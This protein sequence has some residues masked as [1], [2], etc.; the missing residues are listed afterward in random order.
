MRK[1]LIAMTAVSA[2]VL[3]FSSA[4]FATGCGAGCFNH[5]N[6]GNHSNNGNN[7]HNNIGSS[8]INIGGQNNGKQ[9]TSGFFNEQN[10]NGDGSIQNNNSPAIVFVTP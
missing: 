2:L 5:D 3:G 6:N 9:S 1:T 7:S 8:L 4:A 10:L